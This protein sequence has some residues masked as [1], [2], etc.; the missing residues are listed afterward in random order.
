MFALL[1]PFSGTFLGA[2]FV[3]F[4]KVNLTNALEK[5]LLGFAAGIMMAASVWS[6]LDPAMEHSSF[7][8]R[9]SFLPAVTGFWAGII[10]LFLLDLIVPH[11]HPKSSQSEGMKVKL[12]KPVL[13][14]L[15]VTLHNLPEGMAVGTSYAAALEHGGISAASMISLAAGIAVQ[16][17]PEGAIVSIPLVSA[18][19]SRSASF[20]AGVLSGLVE[21]AGALL[22]VFFSSFFLG[23]LPYL[24]S[25]AAGAMVYVVVEDLIP[26]MSQGCHSNSGVLSFSLGFTLMLALDAGLA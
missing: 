3:F 19:Y 22:I 17:I 25:F 7:L 14:S 8:G 16:N 18:G 24:L 15:A 1:I 10:F 2:A 13:I 21:P 23:Y 9:L 4:S 6:L 11:F 26:E 5:R 12:S 20:A